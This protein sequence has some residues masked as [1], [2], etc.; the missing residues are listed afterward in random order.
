MTATTTILGLVPLVAPMVYGTAEGYAKV[1]GPIGL[2]II[3][4][5]LVSTV[6]TLVLLPTIYS[7]IDDLAQGIRRAVAI[8][9]L[10]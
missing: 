4:G 1:W 8:S 10:T 5:L 3:S 2:V 6:L 9:R 7:L